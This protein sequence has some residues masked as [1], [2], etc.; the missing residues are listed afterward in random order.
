M[1][2]RGRLAA[3]LEI[4]AARRVW[5]RSCH[6]VRMPLDLIAGRALA[7]CV[8]PYAA[9]RRLPPGGR[10]LLVSAYFIGSYA[11]VLAV[12]FAL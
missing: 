10:A 2:R 9:W 4:A 12:L 8:H 11:V 3:K 1:C 5:N 7:F 6:E